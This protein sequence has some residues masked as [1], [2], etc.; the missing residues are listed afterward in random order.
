[1]SRSSPPTDNGTTG[2]GG[3][4]GSPRRAPPGLAAEAGVFASLVLLWGVAWWIGRIQEYAPHASLWFPPAGLTF[5]AFLVLGRRAVPPVAVAAALV[6]LSLGTVYDRPFPVRALVES[7]VLFAMAHVG[8]YGL[9]AWTLRRYGAGRSVPVLVTAYLLVAPASA[10]LAAVGGI[11]ALVVTGVESAEAGPGI[12]LPWWLGDFGAVVALAPAL[13][14]ALER[15]ARAAGVP[16]RDD[17][18][19]TA[20]LAPPLQ[21]P[22]RLPLKLAGCALPLLLSLGV[23]RVTGPTALPPGFLV[24]FAIVPL[25]WIAYTDGARRTFWAVAGLSVAIAGAGA[26]LGPGDHTT[27]YQFAMIV[28]AGSAYF[29]LSVP[30][31]YLD[32]VTLRRLATTDA[33]T[34]AM[35]RSAFLEA[36]SREIDRARRFRT[37]LSLLAVDV[38][39][40]K[41]VN[42][43]HGHPVGDAV[44]AEVG[45]RLLRELRASDALGRLGG[46]EF[47]VLLPMADLDAA[48]E[49]AERLAAALRNLPVAGGKRELP[50]TA[51]FGVAQAEP[52]GETPEALYE[53]ADRALYEAKQAGRDRVVASSR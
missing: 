39:R 15:F 47:A 7:G 8:A 21:G 35:T 5:A 40:F 38:D 30:A 3:P 28:L 25:M 41:T 10:L 34:G 37:P 44:L 42:D 48:R 6:T 31:L 4:G 9:G 20:R 12:L 19:A 13:A 53:R 29:G 27:T 17:V 45:R 14:L 51:S 23:I 16:V 1:M 46:D 36:A 32:N 43:T 18:S 52:A 11:S 33:L 26:L 50:V 22:S 2:A 24:F 49:T